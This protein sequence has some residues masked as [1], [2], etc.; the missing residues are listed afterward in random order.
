MENQENRK[1]LWDF[2]KKFPK[3]PTKR[4]LSSSLPAA[5]PFCTTQQHISQKQAQPMMKMLVPGALMH[6]RKART[7]VS[8]SGAI[9]E[10]LTAFNCIH[11]A[12]EGSSAVNGLQTPPVA[13][14]HPQRLCYELC[15]W[16]VLQ[17]NQRSWRVM[18]GVRGVSRRPV[19]II[20]IL[21]QSLYLRKR[22]KSALPS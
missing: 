21:H 16:G 15:T 4:E 19:Q 2:P 14:A 13:D 1:S 6:R 22:E 11:K 12:R 9:N 7:K 8:A 20:D 5:A 10:L 3:C 17:M 18:R